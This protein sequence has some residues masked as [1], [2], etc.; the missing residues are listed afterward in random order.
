VSACVCVVSVVVVGPD[1]HVSTHGLVS[2]DSGARQVNSVRKSSPMD[3]KK[4]T[5]W[6]GLQLQSIDRWLPVVLEGPV[7]RT[8]KKTETGLNGTGKDWT[9]GLFMDRSF[10]VQLAVFHF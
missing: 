5:N 9:R 2:V 7:H 4:T 3:C 8:K 1:L 10:A 6:T